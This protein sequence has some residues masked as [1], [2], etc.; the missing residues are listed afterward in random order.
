MS[1]KRA[2]TR[3]L[4]REDA[5]LAN[6]SGDVRQPVVLLDISRVGICFTS[7]AKL[8]GGS[9]HMLNFNLPGLPLLHE[10]VVEVVHRSESG[11]PAGFRVGARFIH[12]RHDTTEA[13]IQFVSLGT[14]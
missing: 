1:E 4:M 2:H 3:R 7:P 8:D 14:S 11:V 6:A 9:R 5:V 10:T 12:I 13:I